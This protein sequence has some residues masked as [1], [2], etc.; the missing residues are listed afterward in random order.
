M[1]VLLEP[2][3]TIEENHLNFI[4]IWYVLCVPSWFSLLSLAFSSILPT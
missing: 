2:F 3:F 4:L 1:G